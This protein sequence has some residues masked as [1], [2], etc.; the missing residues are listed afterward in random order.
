MRYRLG[1]R[2]GLLVGIFLF[3]SNLAFSQSLAEGA[4]GDFVTLSK[5][6]PDYLNQEKGWFQE[7]D[8]DNK[9]QDQVTLR[10]S[11]ES[12]GLVLHVVVINRDYRNRQTGWIARTFLHANQD[13]SSE[14]FA[15]I[16]SDGR[17]A[18][19]AIKAGN[20]WF[21]ARDLFDDN[22]PKFVE[23]TEP[24]MVIEEGALIP[25]SIKAKLETL[26]GPKERILKFKK[27]DQR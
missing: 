9:F 3:F 20:E 25:F 13:G 22:N 4:Q 8:G 19:F 24:V 12:W 15:V 26:D 16:F 5:T 14:E 10:E 7:S 21:V 27:P 6:V 11:K 23:L 2:L 1:H 18:R 17:Q